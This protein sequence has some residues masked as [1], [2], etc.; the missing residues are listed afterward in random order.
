[1]NEYDGKEVGKP[2]KKSSFLE[3]PTTTKIKITQ[4]ALLCISLVVQTPRVQ[5]KCLVEH[6]Y[7]FG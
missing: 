7:S 1:M 6:P 5:E 2:S 4:C 3:I